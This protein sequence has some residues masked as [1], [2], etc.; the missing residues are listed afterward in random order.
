MTVALHKYV[1]KEF[2]DTTQYAFVDKIA[3]SLHEHLC[4][5]DVYKKLCE[6]NQPGNSSSKVQDVFLEH[7]TQIGFKSEKKGLFSDVPT[8]GLRPDYFLGLNDT[9]IILEVERG[10]TI[11]NN[12]DL[13]DFW[14]CHIC[15]HANNLFLMVPKQL[16]HNKNKKP[17][18]T[19]N[20][21]VD[22]MSPFFDE[23]KYTNVQSLF[24]YGY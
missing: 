21:C 19:Y 17:Y 10:K 12:M 6:A 15:H 3:S 5:P 22:R 20:M 11:M 9:G 13:L 24:I 4:K 23:G 8:S 1:Q 16:T 7:A 18:N 2:K 14:K